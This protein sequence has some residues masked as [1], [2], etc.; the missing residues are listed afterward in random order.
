MIVGPPLIHTSKVLVFDLM[1]SPRDKL[2]DLWAKLQLGRLD[3][4][5]FG[6]GMLADLFP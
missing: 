3:S 4:L 5:I 6:S 2:L 1:D